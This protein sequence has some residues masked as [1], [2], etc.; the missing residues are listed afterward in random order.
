MITNNFAQFSA[1]SS[2][3]RDAAA[4]VFGTPWQLLR[5]AHDATTRRRETARQRAD[6][7]ALDAH[8]LRDIGLRRSLV[9][10]SQLLRPP[11][12]CA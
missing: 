11:F 4:K 12:P 3:L 6:I 7:A 1:R 8:L 5:A 9:D 2:S 10:R